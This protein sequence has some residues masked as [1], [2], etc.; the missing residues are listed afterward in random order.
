MPFSA[1]DGQ[2]FIGRSNHATASR[3][4]LAHSTHTSHYLND[5]TNGP[6]QSAQVSAT[7]FDP[8]ATSPGLTKPTGNLL[9]TLNYHA[10]TFNR[11]APEVRVE[12]ALVGV[13]GVVVVRGGVVDGR[14][15]DRLSPPTTVG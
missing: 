1:S 6:G 11:L 13:R 2:L 7:R 5:S 8:K 9:S 3:S 4:L 12:S 15:V 10:T 14:V